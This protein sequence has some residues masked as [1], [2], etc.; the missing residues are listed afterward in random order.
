[1]YV[2]GRSK[3][4]IVLSNGENISPEIIENE[5]N[6]VE[7]INSS[8]VYEGKSAN[9]RGIIVAKIFPNY[10]CIMKLN[11]DDVEKAIKDEVGKINKKFP[12][13]M[14]IEKVDV[15]KNDFKRSAS[16]K[17]ILDANID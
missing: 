12:K 17:I 8:L 5:L 1:M 7:I 2:T 15:L 6:N 3:N 14:N 9:G 11:I 4:I 13:F 10:T 16:M